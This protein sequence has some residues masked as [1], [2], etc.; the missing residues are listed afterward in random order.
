MS[1]I[2]VT[3]PSSSQISAGGRFFVLL[4]DDGV[5]FY[6]GDPA[7]ASTLCGDCDSITDCLVPIR[8]SQIEEPI[9]SVSCRAPCVCLSH[10]IVVL[11]RRGTIRVCVLEFVVLLVCL[12]LASFITIRASSGIVYA[13]S[14]DHFTID[15]CVDR[16]RSPIAVQVFWLLAIAAVVVTYCCSVVANCTPFECFCFFLFTN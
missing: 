9:Q 10:E 1:F 3:T 13:G 7:I 2:I 11:C 6:L 16:K 4:S 14:V 8:L 5:A 12:S 15:I